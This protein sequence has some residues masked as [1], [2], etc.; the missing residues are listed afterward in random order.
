MANFGRKCA[1]T[2]LRPGSGDAVATASGD[3]GAGGA[4]ADHITA[5]QLASAPQ[6]NLAVDG[7]L[8]A[9]DHQLGLAP[10]LDEIGELEEL[11]ESDHVAVDG[12]VS[13]A[14]IMPGRSAWPA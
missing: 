13:H 4:D 1:L 2:R 11:A 3:A 12:H 7:H 6:V 8:A 9:G 5:V 14:L 10:G